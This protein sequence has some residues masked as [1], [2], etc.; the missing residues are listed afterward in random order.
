MAMTMMDDHIRRLIQEEKLD[1]L[2]RFLHPREWDEVPFFSRLRKI[3][4]LSGL[5]VLE[6]SRILV[7]NA[8]QHLDRILAHAQ[9]HRRD[10]V[11]LMLSLL[12]WD[13]SKSIDTQPVQSNFWLSTDA[14]RDLKYFHL[15]A[16]ASK[17]SRQVIEWLRAADLLGTHEVCDNSLPMV[18]PYLRRVYV[19]RRGDPSVERLVER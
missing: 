9:A 6:K 14:T 7:I 2:E 5:A 15:R 12:N 10:D 8:V 4:F 19:A 13:D 18:D 16:G 3:S 11:V 17:E 1:D